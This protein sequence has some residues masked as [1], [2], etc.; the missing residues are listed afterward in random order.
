MLEAGGR[1]LRVS[2][3]DRVVVNLPNRADGDLPQEGDRIDVGWP[4]SAAV[5]LPGEGG[6][7]THELP[8]QHQP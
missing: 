5:V 2:S 4:A 8:V 1:D 3:A 7:P 6:A